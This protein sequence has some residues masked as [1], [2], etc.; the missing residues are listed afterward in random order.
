RRS[1]A[2][3]PSLGFN[4]LNRVRTATDFPRR[5]IA[6]RNG[7]I[8]SS[9]SA[10]TAAAWRVLCSNPSVKKVVFRAQPGRDGFIRSTLTPLQQKQQTRFGWWDMVT[11]AALIVGALALARVLMAH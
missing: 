1:Y 11:L 2:R 5:A 4:S 6:I 7:L 9:F 3:R 8:F 10:L